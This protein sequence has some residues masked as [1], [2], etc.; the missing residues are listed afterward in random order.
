MVPEQIISLPKSGFGPETATGFAAPRNQGA[1]FA[2]N[3]YQ[4]CGLPGIF[5]RNV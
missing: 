1:H 5:T 4:G 3:L 2:R